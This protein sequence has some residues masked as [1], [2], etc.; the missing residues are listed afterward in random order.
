[1]KITSKEIA[2][3]SGVSV[4]T[5]S[6][7]LN[8]KPGVSDETR[9]RI[10]AILKKNGIPLPGKRHLPDNGVFRLYRIAKHGHVIN[11]RH[12][13]F[14]SDYTDGIIE[15]AKL[16]NYTV[17]V[18]THNGPNIRGLCD[19]IRSSNGISGCIIL[20]TELSPEDFGEFSNLHV[21]VVFLDAYYE[22][23]AG[24]F[25]TMDNANMTYNAVKH[26]QEAGHTK[27]GMLYAEG[28]GNFDIR[29][30]SFRRVISDLKLPLREKWL[31][32]A[33]STHEGSYN[34][35]LKALDSKGE[36]PT[37]YFA[38]N[39]IIAIGGI[40]AL[41]EKGFKVPD[42]ISIIG[43]DDLPASSL[44]DPPLSTMWV[45]KHEIG[46]LSVRMLFN[47]IENRTYKYQKC[48][49]GGELI[50]RKTIKEWI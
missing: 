37:A 46:R 2:R 41:Q 27:I 7:V 8:G 38:C 18:S 48:L 47:R 21:P 30:E 29:Y 1:M 24:D 44:V 32:K 50:N 15:E 39:D 33:G 31:I 25:V 43:F 10:V 4:S 34:D 20:S 6:I 14:I 36:L 17:E 16:Y 45:P 5:V 49:L 42:D 26:L 13:V 19:T 11:E 28:A 23:I 12:N 22:H 40:R 3:L 9:S 35:V